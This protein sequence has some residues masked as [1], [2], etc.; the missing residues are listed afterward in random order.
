MNDWINISREKVVAAIEDKDEMRSRVDE[1][2]AS[3][4][5]AKADSKRL[6]K[7]DRLTVQGRRMFWSFWFKL[8][9]DSREAVDKLEE[10]EDE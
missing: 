9:S 8:G 5:E 6:D 3:L 1:L 10:Q 7:L 2:E 4:A